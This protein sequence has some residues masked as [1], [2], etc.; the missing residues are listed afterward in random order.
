LVCVSASPAPVLE[1]VVT[2]SVA[3]A[4]EDLIGAIPRPTGAVCF[5]QRGTGLVGWDEYAGL[6]VTGPASAAEIADWYAA[7]LAQLAVDDEVG[8]PGSGPVCF[9]SLGFSDDDPS[10][11]VIP[12]TVLGRVGDTCFV[13]TIGEQS[14]PQ[15]PEPVRPPGQVRY[16]DAALSAAGFTGAV[17]QAVRR[18]RAGE[19]GKVVLAHGL[20]AVTSQPVDERYLLA[21]LTR[22]YPTCTTFSVAGLVGASPE[23]LIRRH[24]RQITSRVLAGTAWPERPDPQHAADAAQQVAEHLLASGKD[25]AE[26]RY[27]VQS[28]ADTLRGLADRLEVPS[29]PGALQLANLTHLATDISGRLADG[30]GE[31]P[32]ALQLAAQLHP[33]AAVGGAPTDVALRM[34][35]ELE[36]DPRGRYAA[37]VGWV[38]ARGDGEFAIALRCAEISGRSVRLMAGCGIVAE[39]DPATEAREAQ[40]KMLPVRDALED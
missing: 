26:H 8:V 32:T 22:R 38:D 11:A 25:L 13:T 12:R 14:R 33:T 34:I 35:A 20:Q 36:P 21:R 40:I 30:R 6:T 5:V 3:G 19:A 4:T 10:V 29:A 2:R 28:V 37:P 15:A 24:G 9:V 18:I 31:A 16:G 39:S 23:M 27:A 17:E 7:H 1:R